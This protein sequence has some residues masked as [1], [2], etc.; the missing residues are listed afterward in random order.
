M[1][2]AGLILTDGD[3][4]LAQETPY[5]DLY[6]IPKGKIQLN[7]TP[8]SCLLREVYEETGL[9][10][11]QYQNQIVDLGVYE[12][13]RTKQLHVYYCKMQREALPSI[14]QMHCK[15]EKLDE[16]TGKRFME[17]VGFHYVSVQDGMDK[18][19]FGLS[20]LLKKVFFDI[21]IMEEE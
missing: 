20:R 12:Y 4:M 18:F 13:I 17:V 2:S 15:T 14:A 8:W 11:Q 1:T 3:V 10:I 6:D 7:E 5:S 16:A 21:S 19:S 9:H